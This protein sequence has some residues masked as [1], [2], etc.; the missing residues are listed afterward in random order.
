MLGVVTLDVVVDVDVGVVVE[1]AVELE[2]E[3]EV[4]LEVTSAVVPGSGSDPQAT[5]AAISMAQHSVPETR[6]EL[7]TPSSPGVNVTARVL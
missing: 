6:R 2:V 3:V 5:S 7:I 1:V 4:A